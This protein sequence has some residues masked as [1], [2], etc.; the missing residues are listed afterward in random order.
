M[1]SEREIGRLLIGL[2]LA[3]FL[4]SM[5]V[6]YWAIIG[7]TSILQREDNPR[8]VEFETSILR[9]RIYDRNDVLLAETLPLGQN[10][11]ERTY[12]DEVFYGSLGYYSFRYGTGGV[13]ASF[14]ALLSGDTLPRD[15]NQWFNES[16]NHQRRVGID[17]QLTLDTQIQTNVWQAM[18]GKQGAVVVMDVPSG[19]ILG[20]V[21]L[22]TFNPNVLDEEWE[23]LTQDP[24]K[25][26][27]NRVLQGNYQAGGILQTPLLSVAYLM[28]TPLD[29]P[30]ENADASLNI[31]D[32]TLS[33]AIQPPQSTLTLLEAYAYGCPT[34][35]EQFVQST[36]EQTIMNVVDV[37]NLN[38]LPEI[39]N[40]IAVVTSIPEATPEATET[41]ETTFLEDML[42][43]GRI[44]AN[45]LAVARMTSAILNQGV[46]PM[47]MIALASRPHREAEWSPFTI[48]TPTSALFTPASAEQLQTWMLNNTQ[49]TQISDLAIG[50]QVAVAYSGETAQVWFVGFQSTEQGGRV[51]VVVIENTADVQQAIEV[52]LVA[53]Q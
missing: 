22:P 34:P 28:N 14:D 18:Q 40:P 52:G 47:P 44:T 32:L 6:A 24:N 3:F 50:S 41:L 13:E 53:F 8:L 33:C 43:Q 23:T 9:G 36:P 45:P 38:E 27:F 42:G 31:Q 12:S 46:A 10:T 15:I 2:L 21:S 51:V 25:P 16:M 11:T 5:T 7:D 20:M 26:F 48:E 4:A 1:Q 19:E 35:F 39:A 17:I 49:L 37:L 29:T 30:I